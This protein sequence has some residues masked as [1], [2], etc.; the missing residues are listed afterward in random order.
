MARYAK[1]LIWLALVAASLKL[2]QT[3]V[4]YCDKK[5]CADHQPNIGCN[6]DRK[7]SSKCPAGSKI[8]EVTDELKKLILDTHNKYRS[9]LATGGVPWLPKASAM[10]T[11]TWD[12]DLQDTAQMNANQCV[13]AHDPCHNT[14]KYLNSGQNINKVSTTEKIDVKEWVPKLISSFWD[15]RHDVNSNM[16]SALYDPGKSVMVY[17]FA[18]LGN[19][20]VNKVGCGISMWPSG[21]G[22]NTMYIVCNYSFND[23][24]GLP[25]YNS[26]EPCSACKKGCNAKY[27]GLCNED[28]PVP[29]LINYPAPS[30]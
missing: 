9:T 14:D 16:V 20:K 10:P 26:G 7:L 8:V 1:S 30:A 21:G 29:Q 28:E 12:D 13:K 17:H 24:L 4:D 15:E 6:N 27:A 22:Y 5:I 18:V 11:L 23:F 19:D 2:A 25:I 3:A